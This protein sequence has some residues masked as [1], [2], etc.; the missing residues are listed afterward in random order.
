MSSAITV[1]VCKLDTFR[2]QSF[3]ISDRKPDN[4]DQAMIEFYPRKIIE[5]LKDLI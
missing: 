4:C 1:Y 3:N 5:K 2:S